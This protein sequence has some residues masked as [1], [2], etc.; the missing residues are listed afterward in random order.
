MSPNLISKILSKSFIK[1]FVKFSIVG[2]LGTL[3]NIAILYAFTEVFNVYYIASEIIAF[4]VS[5]LNN[6]ILDKVWTFKEKIED[7]IVLKYFQFFSVSVI[8]LLINLIVL[9]ILVEY[10]VFWYVFAEIVAIICAFLFNFTGN[11]IWTF[12][13]IGE[14]VHF[15]KLYNF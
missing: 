5:G 6:Y 15:S 7:K 12:K 14:R 11:K 2:G 10:F 9:Y 8:S 1:Q 13:K 3:I 4:I